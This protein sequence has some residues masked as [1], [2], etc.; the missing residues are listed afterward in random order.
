MVYEIEGKPEDYSLP[1]PVPLNTV[2]S[3]PGLEMADGTHSGRSFARLV[4]EEGGGPGER[5]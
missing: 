3:S 5:S 2:T 1:E 4:V